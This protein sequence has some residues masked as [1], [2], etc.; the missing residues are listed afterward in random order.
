MPQFAPKGVTHRG[1]RHDILV[2]DITTLDVDAIVNAANTSLLGGGGADRLVAGEG[3][4]IL[5]GGTTDFDT[6]AVALTAM[7][8]EWGRTDL[9]YQDRIAHLMGTVS[10]GLNGSYLLNATTVHDDAA[11]D[12][13]YGG[14][15]MDWFLYHPDGTSA[16]VLHHRKHDEI[17]T[18]I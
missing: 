12:Q 7:L 16:D 4:D 8:A 9:S 17:A 3:G 11:V 10:G 13:L 14:A 1:V 2:A 6:N 18:P 5:I 15:G